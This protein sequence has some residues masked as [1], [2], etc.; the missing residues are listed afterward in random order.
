[1]RIYFTPE[2]PLHG[3]L[4]FLQ[5]TLITSKSMISNPSSAEQSGLLSIKRKKKHKTEVSNIGNSTT[6]QR[7]K[8]KLLIN[9]SLLKRFLNT[10]L[11]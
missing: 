9:S 5:L 2:I 10:C 4:F 8:D 3:V 1:M 7:F 11:F 6:L